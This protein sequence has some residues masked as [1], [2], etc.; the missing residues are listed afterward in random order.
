M[1]SAKPTVAATADARA[2][3]SWRTSSEEKILVG[4]YQMLRGVEDRSIRGT[5]S[6]LAR[7][8]LRSTIRSGP[9][10]TQVGLANGLS[11]ELDLVDLFAAEFYVRHFNEKSFLD[12]LTSCIPEEAIVADIG[13]NF[14]LYALHCANIGCQTLAF[15]PAPSVFEL[16][17]S[18]IRLNQLESL[19]TSSSYAVSDRTA[20][21]QFYVAQ[22]GSFSGLRDTGRSKVTEIVNIRTC[23]LDEILTELGIAKLNFLKIDVEGSEWRVLSGATETL[24]K[25]DQL[26]VFFEWSEK[27]LNE[28]DLSKL[29][30]QTE[31]LIDTGFE[32]HI[33]DDEQ[34]F[35]Q[36][37]S[38]PKD[39]P[40]EYSGS[41]LA[42]RPN[43]EWGQRLMDCYRSDLEP[44][45]ETGAV[46]AA[47]SWL[48][49]QIKGM[50]EEQMSLD[51]KLRDVSSDLEKSQRQLKTV[52]SSRQRAIELNTEKDGLIEE[53]QQKFE[54]LRKKFISNLDLMSEKTLLIDQSKQSFEELRENF[55]TNLN[56]LEEKDK[57]LKASFKKV[58][59][60][61]QHIET[62]EQSA[63][64]EK[65]ILSDALAK[66][67]AFRSLNEKTARKLA[68]TRNGFEQLL[69]DRDH[70]KNLFERL[71]D[72]NA[73]L[74][75]QML[76]ESSNSEPS[77]DQL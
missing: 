53:G 45:I 68:A 65:S 9:S 46:M 14:G 74:K 4:L 48:I 73:A 1:N 18:N 3:L 31:Q 27:N 64:S 25:N 52:Q 63:T 23:T 30:V 66:T 12:A 76:S 36:P 77:E 50:R 28:Q 61:K 42:M 75:S 21:T 44:D 7:D 57:S 39:V 60:L 22:D 17:Q 8:L 56:I 47:T 70:Y 38:S 19:I 67:E 59:A 32:L 13:A 51:S 15:E 69:K 72:E 33:F 55:L 26:V 5:L 24:K 6:S 37:I 16:L 35:S 10:Q 49:G 58:T 11:F 41:V 71:S 43:C 2:N 54:D 20:E 29:R 34:S 62:L 40:P